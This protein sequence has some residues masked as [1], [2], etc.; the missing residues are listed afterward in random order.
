MKR[1]LAFVLA[2]MMLLSLG[3]CAKK[4]E[5]APEPEV[6]EEE[7]PEPTSVIDESI[8]EEVEPVEEP[9]P[10]PTWANTNPLTGEPVE[11]D[12]SHKR[13]VMVMLNNIKQALPQS[14]NSQADVIYEI[15]EEGGI[16]RMLAVYQDFDKV[17]GNLG[18]IRSTR[19]YYV[20][21]V[22]G[23]DGILVHAG[24]SGAAYDLIEELGVTEV[25]ALGRLGGGGTHLFW[26]DKG[27][28][29]RKVATEHT[30][31]F[32]AADLAA[33]LPTSNLRL[34][35]YEGFATRNTF[36]EDATPADGSVANLITV[37]FSGYKTGEF[38]YDEATGSYLVS[39]Y[40][41]P[42]MDETE[43]K[44]VSVKNVLIV[45]T[46]VKPIEGD[47]KNRISVAMSGSGIGYFA[48]GGKYVPI[49]WKRATDTSL[50][51]FTTM[52]GQPLKLGVG[53]SYVNIVP[54][55]CS[56]SFVG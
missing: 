42:Y 15:L 13:P 34:E 10:E 19:P 39:E 32:T 24:G 28:L 41:E 54:T 4:E 31:Y 17:Q 36:V 16:T 51:E 43:N 50:Y 20:D 27:R 2:L 11:E 9:E 8:L 7:P 35:H 48:F 29:A 37:P 55:T 30:M 52:D 40:G 25:D 14:G 47:S 12:I 33:W 6:V 49:N 26:R 21:L 44:Q 46:E 56:V 45:M 5:P 1:V 22:A 53:K 3:A 38:Q 23:M 18:T